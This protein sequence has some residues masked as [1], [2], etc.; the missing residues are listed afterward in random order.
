MAAC[1]VTVMVFLG[2]STSNYEEL[3]VPPETKLNPARLRKM[4]KITEK[5][6]KNVNYELIMVHMCIIVE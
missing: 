4:N 5:K 3:Q 2:E 6:V 1:M